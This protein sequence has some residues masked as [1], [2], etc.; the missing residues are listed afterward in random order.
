MFESKLSFIE[1]H[2]PNSVK[3]VKF[4]TYHIVS[5]ALKLNPTFILCVFTI[6]ESKK[7]ITWKFILHSQVICV[8]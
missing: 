1:I 8:C 6:S 2:G 5:E 7:K 3:K 4:H